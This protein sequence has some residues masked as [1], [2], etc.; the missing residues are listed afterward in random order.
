MLSIV[1]L[2][3][4]TA[5]PVAIALLLFLVGWQLAVVVL[6]IHPIILPSPMRVA[7]VAVAERATLCRAF[8]NTAFASL[9]G[10]AAS[11]V[12]GALIAILFSLSK[13]LRR[14]LYPYVVFLQTVPIVAIA[15]LLITWSGYRWQTVVLVSMII[16]LFPVVSNVTAGLIS[17]DQNLRDLFRLNHASAWQTLVKLHIPFAVSHLLLGAR[18]SAGLAVIGAIV[19]EFF[20]GVS[21]IQTAGLGTIMTSWQNQ[22]RTDALMAAVATSTL[23]GILVLGL[24]NLVGATVLRR[25]TSDVGFESG[26]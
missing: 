6:E 13:W 12:L 7:E 19:G 20:V 25:W 10:L 9:S 23:L 22:A 15:P 18:V 21:G 4:T 16:S 17:V 24:V 14:A 3:T 5:L 26:G 2:L 11:L 1:R 8:I